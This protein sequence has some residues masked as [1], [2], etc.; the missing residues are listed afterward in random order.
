MEKRRVNRKKTS[1]GL[2]IDAA[3]AA[4]G[5]SLRALAGKIGISPTALSFLCVGVSQD[6][7][8]GLIKRMAKELNVT[9]DHLLEMDLDDDRG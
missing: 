3:A 6:C 8:A 7:S 5:L 2:R 9:T 1:Q 4:K